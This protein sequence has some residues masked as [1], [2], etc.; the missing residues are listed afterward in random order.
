MLGFDFK[1]YRPKVFIIDFISISD[2]SSIRSTFEYIL[3]NNNYSFAY[4]YKVNTFY[5][6]NKI[7]ELKE[8]ISLIDGII[9]L[10][11]SKLK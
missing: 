6:D 5:I 9:Q 2:H 10:Y 1:N 11:Q 8:R 3:F 7:K 4:E